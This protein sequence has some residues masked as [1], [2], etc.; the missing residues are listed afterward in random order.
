[1]MIKSILLSFVLATTFAYAN[2]DK[3][4]EIL[5]SMLPEACFFSGEFNQSKQ[6]KTLPVPL[7]SN[8]EFVYSCDSGLIWNTQKPIVESLVFTNEKLHFLVLDQS[9]QENLDGVQHF[10]LANLLLSLMAGDTQFIAN[11]FKLIS[12]KDQHGILTLKPK[13]KMVK[14]AIQSVML[15][16]IESSNVLEISITDSKQQITQIVSSE[17]QQFKAND[18]FVKSCM[19]LS[20]S[21]CKLLLDPVRISTSGEK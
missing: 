1:M 15:K 2:S 9:T 6:I 12:S 16:K 21:S 11:E 10:F 14:Q 18:D 13:N 19:S 7:K 3:E 8:G 5:K 20:T 4:L 17:K